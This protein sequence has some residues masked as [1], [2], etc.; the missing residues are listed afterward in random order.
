VD[1]GQYSN[2]GPCHEELVDR[3][4]TS[5]ERDARCLPV[6]NCT[7]GLIVA[8][9][10][11]TRDVEP[12]AT[13][14]ATPAYTFAPTAQAIAWCGFT[15]LFV[16]A[17]PTS[18]HLD[19]ESLYR[20]LDQFSGK[21]AAVIACSTFGTPPSLAERNQWEML[22]SDAGLSL[23]V[24]SA[25]G[26]GSIDEAGDPLGLQGDVEAFSFHA[27]KPM[28]IGEGGALV[29]AD[30]STYARLRRLINFGLEP[31]STD[32]IELG[33]NAKLSEIQAATALAA[34]DEL[35][36]RLEKRR[37]HIEHMRALLEP[38]GYTF[39]RG[40]E[41]SSC[42]AVHVL[43]PD[44]IVRDRALTLSSERQIQLRAYYNVPL[45]T[46]TL[47]GSC[48]T[49]DPLPVTN[50]LASRSLSL[51]IA[52]DL[53]ETEIAWIADCLDDALGSS[54]GDAFHH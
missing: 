19:P 53:T 12:D 10:A 42:S 13:F 46:S 51:P 30:P 36:S 4:E 5:L 9:R 48:P 37:R 17:D 24:D 18:W 54:R 20:A 38:L 35:G 6:A 7:L 27:T 11:L 49:V 33:L 50:D 3:L 2:F 45:H 25:A 41:R 40:S 21:F 15:P 8:L 1:A 28:A 31:G 44:A 43:A 32:P 47:F 39:Q 23:L 29:T 52:D 34:L 14:V 22:S 16:D 26:W